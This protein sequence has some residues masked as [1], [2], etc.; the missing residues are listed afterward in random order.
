[1]SIVLNFDEFMESDVTIEDSDED[2]LDE[3]MDWL[4]VDS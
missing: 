1:M 3:Q 2:G 4:E